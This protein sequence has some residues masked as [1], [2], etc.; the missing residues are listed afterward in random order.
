MQIDDLSGFEEGT[1]DVRLLPNGRLGRITKIRTGDGHPVYM[2]S[3]GKLLCRHGE[4]A[5]YILARCGKRGI[6]NELSTCDCTSTE[7]LFTK[8][9]VLPPP[10]SVDLFRLLQNL[11]AEKRKAVDKPH[12]SHHFRAFGDVWINS[13]NKIVC[14][15]G[16][17]PTL[18]EKLGCC[19][20]RVPKRRHSALKA[21]LEK[22]DRFD[23]L[24]ALATADASPERQ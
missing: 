13:R 6:C 20:L 7:G 3:E 14:E 1:K 24:Q 15:C 23:R 10:Q 17:G 8:T 16:R 4:M 22:S 12:S 9:D 21:R 18:R 2:G 19:K 5:S 11:G